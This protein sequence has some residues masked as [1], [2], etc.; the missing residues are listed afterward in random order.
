MAFPVVSSKSNTAFAAGISSFTIT[1]PTGLAVGDLMVAFIGQLIQNTTLIAPGGWTIRYTDATGNG[2][3]AVYSKVADA[4]DVAASNFSFSASVSTILGGAILRI[5]G[6][7]SGS[8]VAATSVVF[9]NSPFTNLTETVSAATQ[10]TDSLI[11]PFFWVQDFVIGSVITI[12]GYSITPTITLTEEYDFG[13]RD[14]ASDGGSIAIASGTYT[15]STTFT[16]VGATASLSAGSHYSGVIVINSVTNA[17][18]TS[19]L[20]QVL[21]ALFSNT[22]AQADT[23]G[24]SALLDVSP[25]L[26]TQ[27]GDS[28]T[29]AIWTPVIKT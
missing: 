11:I 23:N 25:T 2:S 26:F 6:V 29:P 28:I 3:F 21:P 19:A 9:T 16:S 12:S 17:S 8:E 14:G 5:T 4:A 24:S 18:G 1:K 7:A 15:G 20:L 27:S 10:S 22:G 13:Y